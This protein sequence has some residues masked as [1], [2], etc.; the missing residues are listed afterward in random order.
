M[1]QGGIRP[2]TKRR[3]QK[4]RRSDTSY[5]RRRLE[6]EFKRGEGSNQSQFLRSIISSKNKPKSIQPCCDSVTN[7]VF[8]VLL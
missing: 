2:L 1:I 5:L 8:M 4:L 3:R 7:K 6:R